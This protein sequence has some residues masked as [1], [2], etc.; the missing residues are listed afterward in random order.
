[1]RWV[2]CEEYQGGQERSG[3]L[4]ASS[5]G[6]AIVF[7]VLGLGPSAAQLACESWYPLGPLLVVGAS[8]GHRVRKRLAGLCVFVS[9]ES[10]WK[11]IIWSLPGTTGLYRW[12]RNRRTLGHHPPTHGKPA[13]PKLCS[14]MSLPEFSRREAPP[15][16]MCLPGC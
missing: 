3:V 8:L 16:L 13:P 2:H 15:F 4:A 9:P 7:S 5:G 14:R 11:G 12:S 6:T 10:H 1:M